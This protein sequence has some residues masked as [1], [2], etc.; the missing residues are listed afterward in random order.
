MLTS[1]TR[2]TDATPGTDLSEDRPPAEPSKRP[3]DNRG[4]AG[5]GHLEDA[6]TLGER[7]LPAYGGTLE[8][9]GGCCG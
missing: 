9:I 1:R 3:V 5:V 2:D 8:R 4:E 7:T 6:P